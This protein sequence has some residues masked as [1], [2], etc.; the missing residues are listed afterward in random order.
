MP[1]NH[2]INI[3]II[4]TKRMIIQTDKKKITMVTSIST[5]SSQNLLLNLYMPSHSVIFI[6]WSNGKTHTHINVWDDPRKPI[7][8]YILDF[9]FKQVNDINKVFND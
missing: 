9:C 1:I 4:I 3:M 6:S 2:H 5:S 8:F 7:L